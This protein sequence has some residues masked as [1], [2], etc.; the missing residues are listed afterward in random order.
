M[1]EIKGAKLPP[2]PH[3]E[4]P[5][6]YVSLNSTKHDNNSPDSVLVSI[7]RPSIEETEAGEMVSTARLSRRG[8]VQMIHDLSCSLLTIHDSEEI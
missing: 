6:T 1:A 4:D 2:L 8:I 5:V 7:G 3:G